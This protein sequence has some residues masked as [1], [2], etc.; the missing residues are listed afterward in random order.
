MAYRFG[1]FTLDPATRQ[2]RRGGVELPL[3]P[4]AFALLEL[5]LLRRPRALARAQIRDHLWPDT[6]VSESSLNTLVSEIR[7]ALGDRGRRPALVRTVHGFGYAFAGRA[8]EDRPVGRGPTRAASRF[9]LCL[10]DRETQLSEGENVLGRDEDA[11]FWIDAP[12]VSRRHARI[13]VEN[14]R[15]LL[16]DMG[17]RNGTWLR[18]KRL[19]QTAELHDGDEIRLGRVPLIFRVVSVFGSTEGDSRA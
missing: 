8:E 1:D 13:L 12:T 5:L 9:R 6:V 17:S 14:G 15:A 3:S 10:P 4:K 16:E 19:E 18:G 11:A 2:L 7:A